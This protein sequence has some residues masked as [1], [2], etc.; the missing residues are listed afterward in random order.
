MICNA[1][2]A[3]L[4]MNPLYISGAIDSWITEI[5][6]DR[7]MRMGPDGLPHPWAAEK[8]RAGRPH[9]RRRVLRP[10]QKWHD[11]KPMTVEDV[12]FSFK[13]PAMGDKSPMYKPFVANIAEVAATDDMHGALQAEDAERR[14]RRL[15]ARQDQ[16]DPQACLGADP[17]GSR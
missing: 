4:A 2:E 15:D 7:L 10:G 12:V 13:A 16:P 6:W 9:D 5:I 17:D 1:A 8:V 14:L 3:M 11:G